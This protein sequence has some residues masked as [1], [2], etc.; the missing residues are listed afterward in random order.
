MDAGRK[1]L[2]IS[3]GLSA[4]LFSPAS[5]PVSA[6]TAATSLSA[7]RDGAATLPSLWQ[8]ILWGYQRA[9]QILG[10]TTLI[11]G[12]S[13]GETSVLLIALGGVYILYKQ[14]AN[15]KNCGKFLWF[16]SRVPDDFPPDFAGKVGSPLFG[17]FVGGVMFAGFYMLTDPV[18]A[19]RT[20]PGRMIFGIL[21]ALFTILIRPIRCLPGGHVCRVVR[22]YL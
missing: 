9:I 11:G 16:I 22:Q 14:A 17:L 7:Y 18:S 19:A 3:G 21:V 2:S 6:I 4:W 15:W 5:E 10:Q 1:I 13:V 20:D 12:G 8:I